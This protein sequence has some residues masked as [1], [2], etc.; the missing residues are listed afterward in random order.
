MPV[1]ST[2]LATLALAAF[3]PATVHASPLWS[4]PSSV[5]GAQEVVQ[6]PAIAFGEGGEAVLAWTFAD[7]PRTQV[8]TRDAT[9]RYAA[10]RAVAGELVDAP[11]A[12]GETRT[13][14]LRRTEAGDDRVRLGVSF[15]R[16]DGDIDALR[17]MD[18]FREGGAAAI[19][20]GSDGRIAVAYV[21]RAGGEDRLWLAIRS[22][23]RPFGAPRVIRGGG[24]MSDVA[25]AVGNGGDLLVA[26][27][28]GDRLEARVQRDEHSLGAV[29]HLGPADARTQIA[30]ETAPSGRML[31]AWRERDTPTS[32][33]DF[34]PVVRAAV[35][36]AGPRAFRDDVVLSEDATL[37]PAGSGSLGPVAVD[38]TADGT[39]TVVFSQQEGDVVAT[40]AATTDARA[41]FG[42]PQ[43]I[44]PR[45]TVD[46]V[47]VSEA[48]AIIVATEPPGST[49]QG[50]SAYIRPAGG[51]FGGPEL[52]A[53]R[54][55]GGDATVAVDPTTGAPTVVWV[56]R[57]GGG[58]TVRAATRSG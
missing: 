50:I 26:Y 43:P 13:A 46:D 38:M 54:E 16:T 18:T 42:E 21:E 15:G 47:A 28:R 53:P 20:A 41:R 17:T 2:L 24:Q 1:R 58:E 25:V 34:V 14:F 39:A 6:R 31:V 7:E 30:A 4:S 5:G 29:Q 45:D 9:G 40:R 27:R 32:S 22:P 56:S 37:V 51:T 49:G 35:R 55:G 12:Y 36:P 23:G 19:D 33:S 11:M 10:T 57:T 52:A 48:G 44:S 8:A 3:L